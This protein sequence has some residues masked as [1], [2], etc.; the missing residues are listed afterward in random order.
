MTHDDNSTD[1]NMS[2]MSNNSMDGD[3]EGNSS[4]QENHSDDTN[5]SHSEGEEFHSDDSEEVYSVGHSTVTFILDKGG[6][7]RVAWTGSDW[8][9]DK[10]LE[11]IRLL[12]NE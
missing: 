10:F 2:N 9:A 11:D 3:D 1:D 7:K 8:N 6:H 12:V 5:E 4:H